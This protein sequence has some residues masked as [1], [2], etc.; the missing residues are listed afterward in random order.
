MAD[1][2]QVGGMHGEEKRSDNR[3]LGHT[4]GKAMQAVFLAQQRH[5]EDLPKAPD[6][7]SNINF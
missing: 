6:R 7:S 3:T 2:N 5:L 4:A 1:R